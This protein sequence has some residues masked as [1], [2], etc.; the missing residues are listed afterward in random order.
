MYVVVI[1]PDKTIHAYS[2][3]NHYSPRLSVRTMIII[4]IWLTLFIATYFKVC[5]EANFYHPTA[6]LYVLR[7]KFEIVPWYF[8]L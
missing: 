3:T 6:V 7:M 2:N 8:H 5:L 4:I 1:M